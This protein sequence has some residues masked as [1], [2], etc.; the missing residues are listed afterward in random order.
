MSMIVSL[1]SSPDQLLAALAAEPRR[2]AD[3][4]Y[5]RPERS[6]VIEEMDLDKAWHGIHFLLNGDSW[7]GEPPLN[8][9]LA[10]EPIGDIDVGYGPARAFR[11]AEVLE[12]AKALCATPRAALAARYD[13]DAMEAE[14]IY[15]SG[16]W[17]DEGPEA[18]EYVLS[19]YDALVEF[20]RRAAEQEKGLI[21]WTS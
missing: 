19:Y 15:P 17:L 14:E 12:I 6:D 1:R 21:V 13:P 20:V 3:E 4:L 18:L 2:I 16:I 11:P 10:G 9:L 5:H 7:G 8:F